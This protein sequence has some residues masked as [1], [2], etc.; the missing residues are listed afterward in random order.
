[1]TVLVLGAGQL[2]SALREAV[3]A[4]GWP[5]VVLDHASLDITSAAK[6]TAEL[7]RYRPWAVVNTAACTAVDK[8]EAEPEVAMAVNSDGAGH[9]ARAAAQAGAVLLH[10]STDHVFDGAKPGP[11]V[12]TDAPAPLNAYGRSKLAGERAVAGAGGRHLTVRTAWL[13]SDHGRKFVRGMLRLARE[14]GPIAVAADQ[15][16]CPTPAN[17]LAAA[18]LT[19]LEHTRRPD[20]ADWGVYHLAGA[21]AVTRYGFAEAIFAAA[22]LA[23]TLK[24]TNRASFGAAAPRPANGALDCGKAA[25]V[26]GIDAIDWHA[27]L[28]GVVTVLADAP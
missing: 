5:C 27:A 20:F 10:L 12:E 4:R 23:V 28:P 25:R 26:F 24:P 11:Y 18:L 13:F 2:G 14:R 3:A 6:V 9:V 8:A 19:M 16:G 17:G 22:G 15:T 7:N 21:P 1:M